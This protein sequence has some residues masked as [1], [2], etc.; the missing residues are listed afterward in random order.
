MRTV[1][2]VR[3]AGPLAAIALVVA[4]SAA[5]ASFKSGPGP[6][7]VVGELYTQ[8]NNTRAAYGLPPLAWN[9]QL[10][11][12]AQGWSAHIA[13]TGDFS[14]QSLGALLGNPALAGFSGLAENIM[15][16][17]CGMSAAEI[18]QDWMSSPAH[19]ANILGNYS[20]IGIGATCSGGTI[21]AVEDFGR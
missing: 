11:G 19:R 5:C 1:R 6:N 12:L 8:V 15:R 13:V 16:G 14:H 10:A 18:N 2:T 21:A 9:D 4:L 7:P 20:A 3:R 17:T